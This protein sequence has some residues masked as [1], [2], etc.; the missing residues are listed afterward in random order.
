MCAAKTPFFGLFSKKNTNTE[1]SSFNDCLEAI[2][3][4][5][6]AEKRIEALENVLHNHIS[7][8]TDIEPFAEIM[9]NDDNMQAQKVAMSILGEINN[10]ETIKAIA[11][12]ITSPDQFIRNNA[13]NILSNLR[14]VRAYYALKEI[15]KTVR[16]E[17]QQF[18]KRALEKMEKDLDI[19]TGSRDLDDTPKTGDIGIVSGMLDFPE[20]TGE[21]GPDTQS[22]LSYEIVDDDDEPETAKKTKSVIKALQEKERASS[23][24]KKGLDNESS[25]SSTLNAKDIKNFETQISESPT[26]SKPTKQEEKD[27]YERVIY[28][29]PTRKSSKINKEEEINLDSISYKFNEDDFVSSSHNTKTSPTKEAEENKQSE[30][31][32]QKMLSEMMEQQLRT[33]SGTDVDQDILKAYISAY[34][35]KDQDSINYLCNGS[36]SDKNAIRLQ[37][38]QALISLNTPEKFIPI[39]ISE[40]KEKAPNMAIRGL[41]PVMGLHNVKVAEAVFYLTD[42]HDERLRNMAI[43]Y[44]MNNTTNEIFEFIYK[45]ITDGS[46]REKVIGAALLA[47]LNINETRPYLKKLLQNI[48]TPDQVI[49]SIFDRLSPKYSDVVIASL[50]SLMQRDDDKIF[51]GTARFL[52]NTDDLI[53]EEFLLQNLQNKDVRMRGKSILLL[54]KIK[55]VRGEVYLHSMIADI[56]DYTRLQTAKAICEYEKPEY[57]ELIVLAM[58]AEKHL[59]NK[60]EFVKMATRIYGKQIT[61]TL[62]SMLSTVQE[63]EMIFIIIESLG[64]INQEEYT[65][66]VV[67]ILRQYQQHRDMR[68]VYYA[69]I[70]QIRLG[71]FDFGNQRGNLLGMLWNLINDKRN[72]TKIRKESIECLYA[73][74]KEESFGIIL[75]IVKTDNDESLVITAMNLLSEYNNEKA[76]KAIKTITMRTKDENPHIADMANKIIWK[77]NI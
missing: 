57:Y 14:N 8:I 38:L 44:F 70:A 68:I 71:N 13:I 11:Y 64:K 10:E 30:E 9:R 73:A 33:A 15:Y 26:S 28:E 41:I 74:A 46:D 66:Q 43:N 19:S 75:D 29:S 69:L 5:D 39:F 48:E 12:M 21:R 54:A 36:Q 18:L 50:P 7:K 17:L 53:T 4:R 76:V 37:A 45:A 6:N 56:A 25:P 62:I 1:I 63:P 3:D 72:P 59:G 52:S 77:N 31:E 60:I 27:P 34:T 23:L 16:P 47:R 67:Q 40:M 20:N 51:S 65:N 49:L 22:K 2:R 35:N 55:S 32:R 24:L 61:P 58:Q 42:N